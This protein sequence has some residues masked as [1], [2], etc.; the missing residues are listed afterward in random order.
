[1]KFTEFTFAALLAFS[2]PAMADKAACSCDHQ[3]EKACKE[4]KGEKC[5][6]QAC[7][8]AKSGKCEHGKCEHHE[9]RAASKEAKKK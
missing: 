4:H 8:C 3:C 1:M 9:G 5:D 2:A 6:C 7:D